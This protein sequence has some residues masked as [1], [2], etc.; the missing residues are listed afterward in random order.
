MYYLPKILLVVEVIRTCVLG[1]L[2]ST[3]FAIYTA[4][5]QGKVPCLFKAKIGMVN[6]INN[7]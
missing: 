2:Y 3:V 4:Q 5:T 6:Y 7:S 1:A